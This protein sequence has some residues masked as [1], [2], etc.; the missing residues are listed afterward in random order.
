MWKNYFPTALLKLANFLQHII[1]C[2]VIIDSK[3]GA[4]RPPFSTSLIN[5]QRFTLSFPFQIKSPRAKLEKTSFKGQRQQGCIHERY[6]SFLLPYFHFKASF[7]R[8]VRALDVTAYKSVECVWNRAKFTRNVSIISVF[9][10]FL[11]LLIL[12]FPVPHFRRTGSV[13]FYFVS[14][15]TIDKLNKAAQR[16]VFTFQHLI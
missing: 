13:S 15:V 8:L 2:A 12:P 5:A 7:S 9:Y 10:R 16:F 14:S 11:S 4:L 6:A 3:C 1:L